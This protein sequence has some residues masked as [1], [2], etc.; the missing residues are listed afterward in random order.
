MNCG[1][2]VIGKR[3]L[4][5]KP[6]HSLLFGKGAASYMGGNKSSEMQQSWKSTVEI[7]SLKVFKDG[8]GSGSAKGKPLPNSVCMQ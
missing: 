3:S 5:L 2:K 6:R 8:V 4:R 7:C 1:A